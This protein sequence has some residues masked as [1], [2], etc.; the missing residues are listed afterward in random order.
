MRM[1]SE[2]VAYLVGFVVPALA[3]LRA[4]MVFGRAWDRIHD[5]DLRIVPRS[6]GWLLARHGGKRVL[7]WCAVAVLFALVPQFFMS[8]SPHLIGYLGSGIVYGLAKRSEV[9]GFC[10]LAP[11][12]I[13]LVALLVVRYRRWRTALL[14]AGSVL[15][16]AGVLALMLIWYNFFSYQ[17]MPPWF[18]YRIFHPTALYPGTGKPLVMDAA[19]FGLLYPLPPLFVICW[20]LGKRRLA[21]ES[22]GE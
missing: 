21:A 1:T 20:K 10:L 12:L 7:F 19:L 2:D 8:F 11:A 3:A 13:G 6:R 17:R 18:A 5:E 9:A 14:I 22:S 16:L 4:S 15:I